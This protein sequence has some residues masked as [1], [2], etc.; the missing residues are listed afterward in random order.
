MKTAMDT[1]G[2]V[3]SAAIGLLIAEQDDGQPMSAGFV[4]FSSLRAAQAAQQMI[5]FS[6]P[7]AME[8]LEAPQPEGT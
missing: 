8:V 2:T 7:F 3:G 5:Q 4:T 1:V 6:E